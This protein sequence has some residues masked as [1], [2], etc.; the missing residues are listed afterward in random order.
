MPSCAVTGRVVHI[1]TQPGGALTY[2][3]VLDHRTFCTYLS[4]TVHRWSVTV[5]LCNLCRRSIKVG[6]AHLHGVEGQESNVP[7]CYLVLSAEHGLS[8]SLRCVPDFYIAGGATAHC[9][10]I[11]RAGG[12][13][14]ILDLARAGDINKV[15]HRCPAGHTSTVCASRVFCTCEC[16]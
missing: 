11:G 14:H 8:A 1:L 12:P 2:R 10:F 15:R 13:A 9:Y 5:C 4:D 16:R 6:A 7:G 3:I